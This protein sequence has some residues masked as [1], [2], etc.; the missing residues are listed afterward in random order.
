MFRANINELK[1]AIDVKPKSAAGPRK[2]TVK[3][4]LPTKALGDPLVKNV[5]L[6]PY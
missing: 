2:P 5:D 6:A 1:M 3:S 4:L